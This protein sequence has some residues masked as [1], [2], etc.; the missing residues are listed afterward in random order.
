MD[1][2]KSL[3]LYSAITS[4]VST[5]LFYFYVKIFPFVFSLFMI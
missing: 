4:I 1:V 5:I 3:L 2:G